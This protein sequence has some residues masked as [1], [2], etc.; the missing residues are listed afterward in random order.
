MDS[1]PKH[2]PALLSEKLYQWRLLLY[3]NGVTDLSGKEVNDLSN[4]WVQ[5]KL[6][7]YK[8]AFKTT[9]ANGPSKPKKG[10]G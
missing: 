5:Y 3:F 4:L 8:T 7:Q 2:R 10:D 6:H 9:C 1:K